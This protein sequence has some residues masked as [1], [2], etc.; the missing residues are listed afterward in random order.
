MRRTGTEVVGTRLGNLQSHFVRNN[1]LF[2]SLKRCSLSC[3]VNYGT[4]LGYFAPHEKPTGALWLT[5]GC[6][7]HSSFC[8]LDHCL[9]MLEAL[10][11]RGVRGLNYYSDGGGGDRR[12]LFVTILLLVFLFMREPQ[13]TRKKVIYCSKAVPWEEPVLAG[14]QCP[15]WPGV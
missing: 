6:P 13:N 2:L 3:A 10:K 4:G 15:V 11:T 14:S 12:G 8:L 1:S 7:P 9:L 5:T